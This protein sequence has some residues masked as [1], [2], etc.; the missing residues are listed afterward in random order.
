MASGTA[1]AAAAITSAFSF[2]MVLTLLGNIKLALAR[3]LD[4]GEG[5]VGGL[6]SA[7]NLALIPMM[8]IC[9]CWVDQYSVKTILNIG[10]LLTALGIFGL[11]LGNNYSSAVSALVFMGLGSAGLGTA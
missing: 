11:T 1:M 8:V 4:I 3:R 7:L 9:G 6:L 5:R 2:G 10:C